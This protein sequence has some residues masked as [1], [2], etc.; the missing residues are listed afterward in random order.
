VLLTGAL[1]FLGGLALVPL[2]A[3]S[4][5][6]RGLLGVIWTVL[7]GIEVSA[8]RQGYATSGALRIAAGGQ[9]ERQSPDGAWEPATLC[10]GSLVLARFAWLRIAVPG[11]RPYAELVSARSHASE[12]WRRLQVIWRHIGAA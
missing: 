3:V 9:V 8:L 10:A 4:A 6:L 5:P 7:C 11:G 2:L 12:D 1:L